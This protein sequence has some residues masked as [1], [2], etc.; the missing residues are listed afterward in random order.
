[1]QEKI[2]IVEDE[3]DIAETIQIALNAKGYKTR[4]AFNGLEAIEE[5]HKDPPDLILLDIIIPE[6]N[7]FQVCRLLKNDSRYNQIPIIMLTAKTPQSD[8]FQGIETGADEYITK[9][10]DPLILIER[11]EYHL[12]QAEENTAL[13]EDIE[14]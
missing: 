13:S 1:V 8:R 14:D 12:K 2:L 5:V 4:I 9:P 3:V 11:V 7:G 10:F 6:M